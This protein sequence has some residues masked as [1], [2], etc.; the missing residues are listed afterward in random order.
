MR[1]ELSKLSQISSNNDEIDSIVNSILLAVSTTKTQLK[2][3]IEEKIRTNEIAIQ[4][5]NRFLIEQDAVLAYICGTEM[6]AGTTRARGYCGVIWNTEH[7]MNTCFRNPLSVITKNSSLQIA[8]LAFLNQA[9][10]IQLKKAFLFLKNPY[11]KTLLES[12][13]LLHRNN[14]VDTNGTEL[15]N[16]FVIK[17]IY[18]ICKETNIEIKILMVNEQNRSQFQNLDSAARLAI[19]NI[20]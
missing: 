9:K 2:L 11:I 12:I 3:M 20:Q 10:T 5:A 1:E 8:L 14:Y 6:N 13:E 16:S 19:R 18:N 17:D 4:T 15:P 7:K